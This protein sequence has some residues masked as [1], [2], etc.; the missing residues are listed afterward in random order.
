MNQSYLMRH[1]ADAIDAL[2]AAYAEAKRVG[3]VSVMNEIGA[4]LS[5]I[6]NIR[7]DA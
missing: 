2:T 4:A 6:N 7:V 1:I 5:R 3:N